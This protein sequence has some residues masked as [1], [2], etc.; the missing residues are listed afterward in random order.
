MKH[1]FAV[2]QKP[3]E[4]TTMQHV[5]HIKNVKQYEYVALY[6]EIVKPVRN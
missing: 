6:G 1:Y 4:S 3:S 2:N 5:D